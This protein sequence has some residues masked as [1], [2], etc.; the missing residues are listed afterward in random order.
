M[1]VVVVWCGAYK[2]VKISNDL[3]HFRGGHLELWEDKIR[4]LQDTFRAWQ[5]AVQW[6]ADRV[7]LFSPDDQI[8]PHRQSGPLFERYISSLSE[9]QRQLMSL[10]GA[11]ELELLMVVTNHGQEGGISLQPPEIDLFAEESEEIAAVISPIQLK[12][13]LDR[14]PGK[15]VVVLACCYAGQ[16]L[17]LGHERRLMVAAC[18]GSQIYYIDPA[19]PYS[20]LIRLVLERWLGAALPGELAPETVPLVQAVQ[21]AVQNPACLIMKHLPQTSGTCPPW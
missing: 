6:K 11:N 1:R 14:L 7:L 8:E 13:V 19:E 20:P 10:T 21:E 4:S 9:L 5:A 2:T 15:Q 18:G 12:N 16:F 17:S 3:E